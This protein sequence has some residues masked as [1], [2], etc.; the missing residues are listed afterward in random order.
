MTAMRLAIAATLRDT[1]LLLNTLK[2]PLAFGGWIFNEVSDLDQEIRG[3]F[4]G[5]DL[6]RSIPI[7]ENLLTIP[8]ARLP[9]L[10]EDNKFAEVIRSFCMKESEIDM[11]ILSD[12]Q[13]ITNHINSLEYLRDA[14]GL[15]S[16]DI[17][18]AHSLGDITFLNSNL[19]WMVSF[20]R[21]RGISDKMFVDYLAAYQ[22]AVKDQLGEI[23]LPITD[24][25]GVIL[26]DN[27]QVIA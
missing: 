25:L 26:Y 6:F 27:K 17:T 12:L 2:V 19:K 24:W 8:P 11:K 13:F 16:Q 23:G 18:A 22:S 3:C 14:N 21:N 9:F 10:K 20:L 1:A 7:I 4:L 5:T 15:F